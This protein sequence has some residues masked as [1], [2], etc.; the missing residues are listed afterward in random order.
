MNPLPDLDVPPED[1]YDQPV[2]RVLT[3]REVLAI[4][5]GVGATVMAVAYAP[6]V[7]AQSGSPLAADS[8]PVAGSSPP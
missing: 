3:R 6:G 8:S 5:G 4:F 7:L 1:D 2:G